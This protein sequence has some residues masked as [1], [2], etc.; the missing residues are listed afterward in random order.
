MFELNRQPLRLLLPAVFFIFCLFQGCQNSGISAPFDATKSAS[1]KFPA[2][3]LGLSADYPPFEFK[4]NGQIV[5]FDVDVAQLIAQDLGR[6]LEIQDMDFGSL[7]PSLQSGRIDLV[8]SGMTINEERKKNVLFSSI[9]FESSFAIILPSAYPFST[10]KDLAG[11]KVGVQL[12]STVEN[13]AKEKAASVSDLQV[14]ALARYP[15]LIQELKSER[16]DGVIAEETQAVSFAQANPGLKSVVLGQ[17][18][19]KTLDK[20][21]EHLEGYAIALGR[22]NSNNAELLVKINACLEKYRK[23]GTLDALKLK[24]LNHSEEAM[25]QH[26]S[27][28]FTFVAQGM[29]TTLKYTLISACGGILI[30]LALGLLKAGTFLPGKRIAEFYTSVFRGTPMLV[31][32]S[33]VYFGAP[34]L[35]H[36]KISPL[37]AGVIAFSLNS[38]AYV[39]E[40]IRAGILGIDKGQYEAAKALDIPYFRMMKDI[41]LPQAIR[42]IL[43]ALVNEVV[44]LLKETAL[45][46][47]LGEE[48][49]MRRAQVV[50]AETYSYFEPLLIAAVCYYVLVLILNAIAKKLE[51]SLAYVSH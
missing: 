24:W 31:Q 41:V 27:K 45:V 21:S 37:A 6:N 11:K 13:Y 34:S 42:N 46:S 10:W 38:G 9:Y 18:Q 26:F 3:V 33:L 7:I 12:G 40:I 49:I 8:M 39:S 4:K 51:R 25:L 48:D 43:P 16:L 2:L 1:K 19:S 22:D 44:N 15:T 47:T 14:V 5:G 30:G 32:L 36:Y 17:T 23:Q 20:Q 29:V 28:T 35:F 50:A